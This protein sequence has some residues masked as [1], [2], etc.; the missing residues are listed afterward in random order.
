M[1]SSAETSG[2]PATA[3][4]AESPGRS[5]LALST[6]SRVAGSA[7]ALGYLTG[8]V[9]GPLAVVVAAVALV[10][11]G[12]ALADTTRPYLGPAAFAV[13]AL[14]AAVGALRW[15]SSS[16]DAIRGA[17][18]VLGPT[19]LIEPQQAAIGAGL[20]AGAGVVALSLW[21]SAHRA[22]DLVSFAWSCGEAIVA[23]LLLA[24]AFWGPALVAPGGGV[25]AELAKDVGAW[26]LV[27]GAASLPA[28]GL[29][30]LWRRLP[31]VWSWVALLV[32][33]AA[34]LAGTILVPGSV[35]S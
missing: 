29:S 31:V 4:E 1:S 26:V 6:F 14:A 5:L 9:A 16:L 24:T 28:V 20:A 18:A 17:Q 21:L 25:A 15:G 22:P 3:H 23:A 30:L 19:V 34:A 12:R 7:I 13:I 11:F 27:V 32:A 10:T 33:V 2:L 8:L 35:A